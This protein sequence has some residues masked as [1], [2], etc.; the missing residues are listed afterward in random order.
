M[1]TVLLFLLAESSTAGASCL[2]GAQVACA[3]LGGA[4]GVQV[5]N[6]D[7]KSV[8]LCECPKIALPPPAPVAGPRLDLGP[9]ELPYEEGATIPVGYE[10]QTRTRSTWIETG[11][12]TAGALYLAG[13]VIASLIDAGGTNETAHRWLYLPV[14]GPFV[15]AGTPEDRESDTFTFILVVDGVLQTVGTI[16]AI[17][18][19]ASPESYLARKDFAVAPFTNGDATGLAFSASY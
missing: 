5:C 10:L 13:G 6:D 15:A 1:T 4:Q 7:G 12:G 18:G 16:A 11:L 14:I 3:C 8:S 2:P 9:R 19:L 17:Y